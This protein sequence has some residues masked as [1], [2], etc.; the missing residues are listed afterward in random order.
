MLALVARDRLTLAA[1]RKVTDA[2]RLRTWNPGDEFR[3][4][5]EKHGAS[6][7]DQSV[8]ALGLTTPHRFCRPLFHYPVRVSVTSPVVSWTDVRNTT[9]GVDEIKAKTAAVRIRNQDRPLALLARW[10]EACQPTILDWS[11]DELTPVPSPCGRTCSP[12]S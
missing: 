5:R 3:S 12:K 10:T 4:A 1:A 8:L 9:T 2:G 6:W 11:Y 7:I